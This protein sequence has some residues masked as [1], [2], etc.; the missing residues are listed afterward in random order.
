M[1]YLWKP[2]PYKT[3]TE[4]FDEGLGHITT[5]VLDSNNNVI[6]ESKDTGSWT[7]FEYNSEGDLLFYLTS[8]GFW[9]KTTYVDNIVYF[10]DSDGEKIKSILDER[11]NTL[12][13]EDNEG[14]WERCEYD[15]NN[16]ITYLLDYNNNETWYEYRDGEMVY[17]KTNDEVRFDIR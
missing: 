6:L 12:Y 17:Y 4:E 1:I 3:T 14:F 7:K 13:Y 10:E 16:N 8:E 11:G 5:Y 9:N 2:K 15:Q